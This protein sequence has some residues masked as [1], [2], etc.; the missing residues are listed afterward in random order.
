MKNR[1]SVVIVIYN[2]SCEDSLTCQ[3]ILKNTVQPDHVLVI[4]NSTRD[5]LNEDFCNFQGWKYHSMNG[6]AGLSKAYNAA[7]K[8]LKPACDVIV[9]A[10]DDTDFPENYFSEL[11]VY[12]EENP[13]KSLFVP[14]VFS[15]SRMISP[16]IAGKNRVVSVGSANELT[17]KS[18]T[19][20][21]S[22]LAVRTELYR[23]YR[24]DEALFLDC[25]DHD[26]MRWCRQQGKEICIMEQVVLHQSFFADSKPKRAS[27]II[28]RKIFVHDFR[29]YS[30][31]CGKNPIVMLFQLLK[32]RIR[33]ELTCSRSK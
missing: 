14:L 23:D 6:N 1:I 22:G 16:S 33:L 28:R 32:G 8:I 3:K 4:D 29:T 19:A 18:L 31:K 2:Q 10:D 15:D 13:E 5:F 26:F 17:N 30:K 21:N 11:S 7:L 12:V 9:W 27:A 20:I 25:I 24:Y